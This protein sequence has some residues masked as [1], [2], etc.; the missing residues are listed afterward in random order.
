MISHNSFFVKNMD[1]DKIKEVWSSRI[2]DAYSLYFNIRLYKTPSSL[3]VTEV[4]KPMHKLITVAYQSK[5][6]KVYCFHHGNDFIATIKKRQNCSNILHCNNFV[7]PTD[8]IE[9]RYKEHISNIKCIK[10]KR[11][12]FTSVNSREMY[13]LYLRNIG[14]VPKTAIDTV[15]IMGL[16]SNCNRSF[17]ERGQFFYQQVDLVYRLILLLKSKNKKV[18]YKVHPERVN[19]ID[20]VFDTIVDEV[21]TD[22]FESV[23]GRSDLLI[24]TYT[25]TTTFGYALTTN[26]PI[27]L[28]DTSSDLRDQDYMKLLDK[29]IERVHAKINY[30]TRITFN[31]DEFIKSL[32]SQKIFSFECIDE[33]YKVA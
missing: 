6:C 13:D 15:M 5:G 17:G 22:P 9:K 16:P 23:W 2:F 11:T 14:N 33:I 29:R 27:I 8:G 18:L 20:G 25:S 1:F 30:D 3:L 7:L 31:E 10:K 4:S 32:E 24:F 12:K 28:L 21:V 19:E 26:L